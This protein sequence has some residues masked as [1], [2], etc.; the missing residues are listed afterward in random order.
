MDSE[1][2]MNVLIEAKEETLGENQVEE[3]TLNILPIALAVTFMC[4]MASCIF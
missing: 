2:R 1:S 4:S 3:D